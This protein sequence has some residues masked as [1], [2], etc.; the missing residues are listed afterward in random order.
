M[1]PNIV[2]DD[3]PLPDEP[4]SGVPIPC[5]MT[6]EEFVGWT[7][8]HEKIR[9]EWVDGEVLPMPPPTVRHVRLFVWLLTLLELYSRRRGLGQILGSE[10]AVRLKTQG[11][12]SRRVPDIL[13]VGHDRLHLLLENHLD[14]APDL[15]VEI[16][17]R[18]SIDRDWT[19]KRAEYEAAGV[20][21][22]WIIDTD[23][24]RFEA[25]ELNP[26]G[27]F[28]SIHNQSNDLFTSIVLQGLQ[29]RI[30]WL[31]SENPPDQIEILKDLG[32]LS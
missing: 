28:V 30:E 17:S 19:E 22:Y 5:R 15:V 21:E 3:T 23:A 10:F 11:Q 32:V 16:V 6:E 14:G 25:L 4:Q 29:I 13:F 26:E 9:V 12:V 20:P 1:D 2:T 18:D 31:W 24:R 7:I 27:R 8:S